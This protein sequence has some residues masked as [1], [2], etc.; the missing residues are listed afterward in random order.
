MS[1]S[2]EAQWVLSRCVCIPD[3][4]HKGNEWFLLVSAKHLHLLASTTLSLHHCPLWGH[5]SLGE[6]VPQSWGPCWHWH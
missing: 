1:L 2:R 4:A 6:G 5:T 3:A